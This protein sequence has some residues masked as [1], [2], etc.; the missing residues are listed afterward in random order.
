MLYFVLHFRVKL[1]EDQ[2]EIVNFAFEGHNLLITAQAGVGKGKVVKA[3]IGKAKEAGKK[4]GVLF[5]WHC[6]SSV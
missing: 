2:S 1:N 3:L 5:E 6:L 4:I